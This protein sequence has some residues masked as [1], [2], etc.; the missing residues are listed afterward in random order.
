MKSPLRFAFFGAGFWA[1]CQLAAWRELKG[2]RCVAIYN[3][4]RVKAAATSSLVIEH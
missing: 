2:A 3:R 1:A 4:T